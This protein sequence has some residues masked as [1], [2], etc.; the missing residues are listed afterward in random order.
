[1]MHLPRQFHLS[2]PVS[3]IFRHINKPAIMAGRLTFRCKAS[4][5]MFAATT[6]QS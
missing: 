2:A 4:L 6:T 5:R 3:D 1:M